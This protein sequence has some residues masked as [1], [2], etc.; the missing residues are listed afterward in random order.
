[1]TWTIRVQNWR[2]FQHYKDRDPPW[3]K[4]HQRRLLDKPAWRRLHGS[5]AKLL[6]DL[7]MLAAGTKEGE[8]DLG[9]ADLAYRLRSPASR[10]FSDLQV[11]DRCGFVSLG[12]QM[13]ASASTA[14]AGAVPEGEGEGETE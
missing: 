2:E 12:K 11:L 4:L 7:W 8:L 14:Q 1:M 6:V 13:L 5:A 3:I 9:I 10:V